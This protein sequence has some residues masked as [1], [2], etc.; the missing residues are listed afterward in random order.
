MTF[1]DKKVLVTGGASGI[2]LAITQAMAK[3]GA[4]VAMTGRDAAKLAAVARGHAAITGY[5][6]DVTDNDAV[7]TLRDTLLAAGGIDIL[8]N[9]AGVMDFFNVLVPT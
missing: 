5:V 8:A 6:F 1:T 7:I 3:A 9:N 4:N 2:G